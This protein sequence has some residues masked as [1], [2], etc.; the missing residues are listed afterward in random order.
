MDT[1][2]VPCLTYLS[3]MWNLS[4]VDDSSIS[5]GSRDDND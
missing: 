3:E 2:Q 1:G 4:N 5:S